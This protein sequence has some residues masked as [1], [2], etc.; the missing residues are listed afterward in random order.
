[1]RV[2]D[3]VCAVGATVLLV[4]AVFMEE[5]PD[6]VRRGMQFDADADATDA[7]TSWA[8]WLFVVLA[9]ALMLAPRLWGRVVWPEV[10]VAFV[11]SV[12]V[13]AAWTAHYLINHPQRDE[14]SRV[15]FTLG[16][17]VTVRALADVSASADAV[18]LVVEPEKQADDE[19][20]SYTSTPYK[21][22]LISAI[23]TGEVTREITVA[24][25]R[26]AKDA[27]VSAFSADVAAATVVYVLPVG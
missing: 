5:L 4:F 14:P 7:A 8:R 21:A 3:F 17:D 12:S 2:R 20:I 19:A 23:T 10:A 18:L 27:N 26:G 16:D 1:M 13:G 15:A 25:A 24:I 11:V 6:L 9:I 22:K